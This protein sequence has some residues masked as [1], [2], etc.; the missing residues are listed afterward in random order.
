MA[1][2]SLAEVPD[3]VDRASYEAMGVKSGVKMPLWAEGR[4]AGADFVEKSSAR[5]GRW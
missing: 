1:F 4:V 3:D 2:S 5:G